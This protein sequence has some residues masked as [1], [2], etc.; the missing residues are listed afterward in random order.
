MYHISK[1]YGQIPSTK[2]KIWQ[3]RHFFRKILVYV[4]NMQH[5]MSLDFSLKTLYVAYLT[6]REILL[7]KN[8]S[9]GKKVMIFQ[10]EKVKSTSTNGCLGKNVMIFQYEQVKSR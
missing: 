4:L 8:V 2:T 10:D 7:H 6:H 5:I 1:Y 9:L 3:R